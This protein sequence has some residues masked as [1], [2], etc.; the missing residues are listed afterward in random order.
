MKNSMKPAGTE[1][2]T[3]ILVAKHLNHLDTS[4]LLSKNYCTIIPSWCRCLLSVLCFFNPSTSN[5]H[6]S[7]RT[8][9]LT[10]KSCILYNY[11]TNIGN[12]YFKDGI[13][14]RV[15]SLQNTVGFIILTIWF[16]YYS[17][18]IYRVC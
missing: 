3:F 18:F 9:P 12:E 7:G 1:P 2:A 8:A 5:D 6:N 10:S 11:S 4:H 15:F 13:Y 14:S 16:L 17:H